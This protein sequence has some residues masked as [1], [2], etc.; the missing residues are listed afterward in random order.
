MADMRAYRVI[1]RSA[2]TG[3][4]RGRKIVSMPPPSSGGTHIIEMLNM[5]ETKNVSSMHPRGATYLHLLSE[6]MRRAF[7]DRAKEMGDSDYVTVPV[8]RLTS[9]SYAKTM[10]KSF[11]PEK[12]TDSK[13]LAGA[14]PTGES[15]STSHI[16]VVDQWGNA[17]AT[18]QTVN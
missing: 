15:P 14:L 4:Y 11:D 2:V 10:M 16:S 6:V 5:L 7:A 9:K 18:T 12:V 13:S 3:H 17:V 1:E 8:A